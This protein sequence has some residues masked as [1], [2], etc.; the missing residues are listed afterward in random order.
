MRER[1]ANRWN[2]LLSDMIV[3]SIGFLGCLGIVASLGFHFDELLND[4]F[5]PEWKTDLHYWLGRSGVVPPPF[6]RSVFFFLLCDGVSFFPCCAVAGFLG[7]LD[8]RPA[9]LI[10]WAF[11]AAIPMRQLYSD[12]FAGRFDLH[13][14]VVLAMGTVYCLITVA[15]TACYLGSRKY[16]SSVP[17]IL[18]RCLTSKMLL[19]MLLVLATWGAVDGW[20]ILHLDR[21]AGLN[22]Q[23]EQ[24]K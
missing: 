4:F 1:S 17:S 18:T 6:L 19:A 9:R 10:A 21:T 12:Y 22:S 7:L 13:W 16:R 14:Q 20:R 23:S 11:I 15:T 5:G 2:F 24:A 3:L 8:S